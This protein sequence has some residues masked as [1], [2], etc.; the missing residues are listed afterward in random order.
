[1]KLV[2]LALGHRGKRITG[3]EE[4]G[5]LVV[6]GEVESGT[7][8]Q[9]S[10]EELSSGEK[11]ML[12]MLGYAAAFLRGGGLVLFDD[13]GLHIHISMVAQLMESLEQIVRQRRGQLIVAS[14]SESVWDHFSRE[15][16]RIELGPWRGR[17]CAGHRSGFENAPSTAL[18]LGPESHR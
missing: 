6:E 11:Q 18:F 9:H 13:P 16:E 7:L 12:L 3:F 5:R 4:N 8:F 15:A 14:H 17:S 2:D 1:L 10:I